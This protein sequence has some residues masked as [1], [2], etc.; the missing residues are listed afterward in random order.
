MTTLTT[1]RAGDLGATKSLTRRFYGYLPSADPTDPADGTL[2][3]FTGRGA[4]AAPTHYGVSLTD[5]RHGGLTVVLDKH[6]AEGQDP[7][8]YEVFVGRDG[9]G[10]CSCYGWNRHHRC[11]HLAAVADLVRTDELPHPLA[12][13]EAV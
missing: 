4:A 2:A 8:L 6:V 10:R 13:P 5:C 1:T 3:I 7:E 9:T 12:A 11:K